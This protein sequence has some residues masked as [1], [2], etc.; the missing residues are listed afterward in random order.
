MLLLLQLNVLF[1]LCFVFWE[2]Q[3]HLTLPVWVFFLLLLNWVGLCFIQA[4]W[5]DW[6]SHT[7]LNILCVSLCLALLYLY[8]QWRFGHFINKVFGLGDVFFLY[9]FAGAYPTPVFLSIWL[10]GTLATLFLARLFQ[11]SVIPYAG[12]LALFNAVLLGIQFLPW[13]VYNLY[14][15]SL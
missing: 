1:V 9:L 13:P 2:D 15:Y 3:R 7:A 14:D 11:L 8:A 5:L 12:G 6:V 4:H 10:A